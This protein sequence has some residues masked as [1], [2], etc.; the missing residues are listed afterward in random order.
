MRLQQDIDFTTLNWVKQELDETLK[1][2]RQALEAYVDDPADSS[3]MRF[4][5]TYLHQVQGTLRMVEL[6]GAAM[7]VE[8]MERVAQGL[9]DDAIRNKNDAYEVLMRGIVQLPD[10]LERLQG[11]HK[12]I[13]IVLLPLLNDLRACRG[14]KLL[15][16]GV[17]FS[18][19]L[20]VSMPASAAGPDKPLPDAELKPVASRLRTN[21]QMALVKWLRDQTS[22]VAAAG[23]MN[24]LDGL[25]SITFHEEG[26]RLWWVAGGLLDGVRNGLVDANQA[27]KLLFGRVDREIK[28]LADAGEQSFKAEPPRDL[29]KNLLYYAAHARGSDGR[30]GELKRTYK[31][32][33][34]LPSDKE[35]EHARG[36]L[37]G[38]NKALLD[39]V[40][41]AIKEDLMRVK[42]A[43]DLYLRTANANPADL[44][45]QSE[46]LDR[47][48]DT[49]GMLG[50]GVPRRVILEQRDSL[51]A[52]VSGTKPAEEGALLDIAG[53][54]L[55]VDASL[56]DNIDRLGATAE[57]P[58][59][60]LDGASTMELP[61][62][63]VRKILEA[64]MKEVQANLTAV[65]LDIVAFIESG[66]QHEKAESIPRLFDEIGGAMRMVQLGEASDL[67]AAMGKFIDVEVLR[68]KRVPTAD[69]MDRL[70]D[71]VASI[72]YYLEATHA[73]RA[74][75]EKIL[76]VTR[77][78][79]EDLG[80]WPM[81]AD[82]P[83]A[84]AD[85]T[86]EMA[87]LPLEA[88][89]PV[90]PEA[91][92]DTMLTSISLPGAAEVDQF[93]ANI[94]TGK[95]GMDYV[96]TV[97]SVEPVVPEMRTVVEIAPGRGVEDL[98]VGTAPTPPESPPSQDVAGLKFA[99][100]VSGAQALQAASASGSDAESEEV[101]YEYDWIEEDR[102]V[103]EEAPVADG[104]AFQAVPS[105]DIDEEI[106]E[107][108]LEE[109]QEEVEN[110]NRSL[111]DWKNNTAD[112]ERLKPVRRSFHTM[113][114]S[115]RL[116]GA[117]ALGEF[118][119]KVE[120][121]LNRVLDKSI[122]I[123]PAV[124]DL[125]EQAVAALPALLAALRGEQLRGVDIPQIIEVA[126]K[127]SAGEEAWVRPAEP[128]K[129]IEKVRVQVKR[130]K[131]KP[132]VVA[133]P[134]SPIV[135]APIELTESF[136]IHADD[137]HTESAQ[138][139]E[140]V[141]FVAT[142][143]A[144]HSVDPMMLEILRSEVATHL[145]AV[146]AYLTECRAS[147]AGQ[148]VSESL[149]RA[150]HTMHGAVAMVDLPAVG[151]LLAP[152]EGYF[153]R[154]RG[155]GEAPTLAGVDAVEETAS[156]IEQVVAGADQPEFVAPDTAVLAEQLI[157][158]RNG[159]PEPDS[160]LGVFN[161]SVDEEESAVAVDPSDA[162]ETTEFAAAAL[163]SDA[164]SIEASVSPQDDNIELTELAGDDAWTWDDTAESSAL[165]EITLD[166]ST[167]AAESTDE[168][169]PM[170]T[171]DVVV[172]EISLDSA[173]VMADEAPVLEVE[174]ADL[175][176]RDDLPEVAA[177]AAMAVP[178]AAVADPADSGFVAL[179]DW[180]I[181]QAFADASSEPALPELGDEVSTPDELMLVASASTPMPAEAA[182]NAFVD[183]PAPVAAAAAHDVMYVQVE[184]DQNP[185]G[186][187][188]LPD[189]DEDLL[190]IFVQEGGDILDAADTMMAR[191]R[192]QP[193]EREI[194]SG[195]QRELHTLKG[196]S[197]MAGLAPIGD[198]SHAMEALLEL[199][200]DGR[201]SMDRVSLE[202]L[203]R[204]FDRLHQLVQRVAKRQAIGMPVNVIAR[205]DAL[206]AGEEI[207]TIG[208]ASV[209]V[210]TAAAAIEP[211]VAPTQAAPAVEA[212][213]APVATTPAPAPRA[214]REMVEEVEEAGRVAQEMIRVRSD[215]LD[216]LVNYAGEVSIY[217]SRLE[218]QMGTFRFNLQELDQTVTR[219]REQL[220]KLEIE[221]EAQIIARYQRE[222][223]TADAEF[224]PLELDRFSTL[225]QLSRA[226]AESVSDLAA[227]QSALDDLT[228]QAE[229][230]LLQQS[231]VS[232]DLQEGLMRT[233]MVPFDS[234]VPRLRRL[235]RQTA[236]E[237]GKRAQL[238]V[239]GAQGEMDRNVLD[240]MTA[241]LEH[242]LRNSLAH[243]IELPGDR[244]DVG[245]NEEGTVNIA[246]SRE[247]TEV[248]IRVTDD[249][250]GMD[251]DAIRRKAIE[252]GL[253]KPDAQL[254][255][256]DLFGFV[257][258][259]GFSTAE[260]V[261]KIAGRGV[262]MDVVH[263]EIKQLGG[264]LSI[265][266]TR[267]KGS[268]FTVRLPF[269]LAVTQAIL[270]RL[271][272]HLFA[273][274]MS[275]VQGVVRIRR[276]DLDARMHQP[277]PSY[278]YGGDDYTI[279]EMHDLLG[280]VSHRATD[281][282]QVPLLM[283][284]S[285]DQRA[286]VRVDAVLGSREVVVKSVGPQISSVPGIFGATIM[287]D[288]S[289]VMILD[290][291]PL[292]RKVAALRQTVI[293]EQGQEVPY[294]PVQTPVVA[295]RRQPLVMVVDDSITMR[296]VTS[297]VLERNDI[298]V[299]T[300]K[301]GLDAVEKI[302]DRIPDLVLLDIEMP[303]MDGYEFATYMRND[304]R[305]KAVPI[306]MITSRTGEKH[307]QRAMEIGVDRY[308]G[309]P[310]QEADLL[311]N[312][313]EILR[314]TRAVH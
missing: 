51:N 135:E 226:L 62:V 123:S 2:A 5:A 115:G 37:S 24:A 59:P 189:M 306:I 312:V 314:L 40:S 114:G 262:G 233:R 131:P 177:V 76:D 98:V 70:A 169:M 23:L 229:T 258:E 84:A 247:A 26:R 48:A 72:E 165:P 3:L 47:A 41:T 299:T 294:L 170:P 138:E 291:A 75:R 9:L 245:K 53:A 210:E 303:R 69:Q 119:W 117:M 267:G 194:V 33:M 158:F 282:A 142:P 216:N 293:D 16:E 160:V 261:S 231:R 237:L 35:I 252:R 162:D 71:A 182:A 145:Q 152:L 184:P 290:M 308:L 29:V 188:E 161:V 106:R 44:G 149:L 50:L 56:D 244:A 94:D 8:E 195:L 125:L 172:E 201:R 81:P 196:G 91:A 288:G 179:E 52:I 103:I 213:P 49:L 74:G 311:R 259:T 121:M 120:N 65:K 18:P 93:V 296:K 206:V 199:V 143:I 85:A 192:E 260:T 30:V 86:V 10:Y 246:I 274:P 54:L 111:P 204:G 167:F 99:D 147:G 89:A 124:I 126:E 218:Q 43:L 300:A 307:R 64:L 230:L 4:C 203:E 55:F 209:A 151:P 212:S 101:E 155:A 128:V 67:L 271:G 38:R 235:M 276:E 309:K 268:Q 186:S 166:E 63:E 275:S 105:D 163:V 7:V 61:Q 87:T 217:R 285:G 150:V 73:Q 141:A 301:D 171:A 137:I 136:D 1:Q 28:R 242:M 270:V 263:S 92:S 219:L 164:G 153:K 95:S 168:S 273:V 250:R 173:P 286:A 236:G 220:R 256:R 46:V 11:G 181:E 272:E 144:Q 283:I 122:A 20:S 112:F 251:R 279:Y 110:L 175:A 190:E 208:G 305:L 222:H 83:E 129:R 148:P 17:L 234:V 297:R 223:E 36:T 224:D 139:P 39:T 187:L 280:T 19:D 58:A 241:P 287:G 100:A 107:V 253:M 227:L 304:P 57:E 197:R 243:G 266:S 178:D 257:L 130:V 310:Y 108:F 193:H 102:E 146:R 78:S 32:E 281:D 60:K 278:S 240:R 185:E 191:L 205:F 6:Y 180:S 248:V 211:A 68:R 22:N 79:L 66:W 298:E 113:K 207:P 255:D 174:D 269:T 215:L 232:S 295:E 284:R 313:D 132:V 82:E 292:V 183:V 77:E 225:Q 116:V 289:V 25:R 15:S 200:S 96:E 45:A 254:S 249:G 104:G 277:N 228:R 127:L 214:M 80:Y 221:T 12:D 88:T 265:D 140:H 14:E 239:E 264:S 238:R 302:Q 31:L 157:R 156:I 90:A 159:L 42:D 13:P 97:P 133:P 21:Y 198:L 109:V 134:P 27:V 154:L 34:L 118:S 176:Y 202:S